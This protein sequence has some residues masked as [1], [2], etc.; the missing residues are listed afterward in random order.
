MRRFSH[1][2]LNPDLQ[3]NQIKMEEF[4]DL[5]E[6]ESNAESGNQLVFSKQYNVK[7]GGFGESN[8]VKTY[9]CSLKV[10][11]LK[12]DFLTFEKLTEDKTMFGTY[13]SGD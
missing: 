2:F 12:S 13:L 3:E 6:F 10:S 1:E 9:Y 4:N 5:P 7:I 11:E 8:M